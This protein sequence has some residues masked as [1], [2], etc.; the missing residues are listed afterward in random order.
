MRV[1]SLPAVTPTLTLTPS[2]TLTLTLILPLLLTLTLTLTLPLILSINLTLGAN[3]KI[4]YW[5]AVDA[6]AIRIIDGSEDAP[7]SS[8]DITRDGSF[9][10]SGSSDKML[11]LWSYDEG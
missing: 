7:M 4:T 6:Q 3:H 2:L 11:K 8:L 1:S 9:F 10:V 5:D